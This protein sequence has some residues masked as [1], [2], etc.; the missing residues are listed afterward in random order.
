VDN[1]DPN[2]MPIVDR[3]TLKNRVGNNISIAGEFARIPDS[4][5]TFI[6]LSNISFAFT[7]YLYTSWFY[8]N[9]L[10]FSESVY[11][12]PCPDLLSSYSNSSSA[13]FP[14]PYDDGHGK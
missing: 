3:I 1:F 8:S 9:I 13:C 7:S 2:A 12:K 6:Y 14:F 11:R 5:F 10:G 4:P